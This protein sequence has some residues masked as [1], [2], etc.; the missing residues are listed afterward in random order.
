MSRRVL[1]QQLLSMENLLLL[2]QI[3]QLLALLSKHRSDGGSLS[4]QVWITEELLQIRLC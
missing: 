3:I 2:L 4:G 1:L